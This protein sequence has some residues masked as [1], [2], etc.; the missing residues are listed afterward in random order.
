MGTPGKAMKRLAG[1]GVPVLLLGALLFAAP[2]AQAV[3]PL[4][5]REVFPGSTTTDPKAEYVVLQMT[6][7]GQNS[8]SGQV[9]Q[10]YSASGSLA[11]SYA[12]PSNV[13]NGQSQRTVLLATQEAVEDFSGLPSPD[14]NLGSASDRIDPGGGGICLTGSGL[15]QDDCVTWGIIPLATLGN[16]YLPDGQVGNAAT[17]EDGAALQRKINLGCLT[18]LDSADD[19][20][21]SANDFIQVSPAPRSNTAIPTEIRCPPDTALSTFP[22]HPTNQTSASFTYAAVPTE[23]GVSFQ[24]KLDGASFAVCP[25]AGK[26]YPGPLA[27]GS[28]TFTVKA[29]GEGGE[30]PSP[31]VFNWTVDAKAPETFIDSFPPEPSGGFEAAFTYHSSES[32]SIFK[33]QLDSEAVQPCAVGGRSYF[34]LTDGPHTF[35]VWATDNAGNQDPTPAER[36]FTVQGVIIDKTPPDTSIVSFPSNPSSSDNASFT[37]ASTEQGSSFECSLNS[38]PFS[39]CPASGTSYPKLRNGSYLF[40]V[41]ATDRAGNVDS[42]PATYAWTVAAPLPKVTITKAPPGKINLK[43]GTK[44]SVLFKFKADKPGSSFR[45]RLDKKAF[46]PC[47]STTK[48]KAPV[49]KHRFEVYAIDELGNVGTTTTRRIFRVAKAGGGGLF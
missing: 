32:G 9:L 27:E 49:G 42:V 35:R 3:S 22:V 24:C 1:L 33:C 19:T 16:P 13:A 7:D 25:G 31:K 2:A 15:G 5:V 8:I 17:I 40:S 48:L 39:S 26:S 4:K 18:Y 43:S 46:V 28:H 45:C 47:S 29:I 41:R 6:A 30:D 12:I 37:Y 36:T 38:A 14:F 44:A 20:N 23:P 11:S 21:N 34:L 10:F